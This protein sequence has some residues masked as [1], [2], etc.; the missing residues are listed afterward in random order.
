MQYAKVPRNIANWISYF[1]LNVKFTQISNGNKFLKLKWMSPL[2][3]TISK[4][5]NR[6]F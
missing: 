2:K 1:R 6:F 3:H 5:N 4:I